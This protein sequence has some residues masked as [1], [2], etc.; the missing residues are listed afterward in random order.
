MRHELFIPCL[1]TAQPRA[2]AR[3]FGGHAS[4]YTPTTVKT[5]GFRKPHPIVEYRYAVSEAVRQHI[6]TPLEGPISV[7]VT[8]WFP[9]TQQQTKKKQD[10]PTLWHTKK[11]DRDN[12]DKGTLDCLKGIAWID[13]TQVCDGRLRKAIV[14]PG[15][16]T[17]VH[18][19][20]E[21][22]DAPAPEYPGHVFHHGSA[23]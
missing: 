23:T 8:F 15:Q 18:I 5:G 14:Q 10:N 3:A 1:P 20:I 21:T 13:D 11:P 6:T 4:V 16:P 9:R 2:K 22:I 7:S 12:L 19:V 17:G